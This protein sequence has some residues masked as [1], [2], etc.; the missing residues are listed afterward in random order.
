MTTTLKYV[1]VT[2][3]KTHKCFCCRRNFPAG[4][5]MRYWTVVSEDGFSSGYECATCEELLSLAKNDFHTEEGYPE[6]CVDEAL[7]KGETPE[8]LLQ[9]A[10]DR[11]KSKQC[12]N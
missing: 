11:I 3:R 6:G 5:N 12:L 7:I 1:V 9:N 2:T 8:T 10:R 4:T